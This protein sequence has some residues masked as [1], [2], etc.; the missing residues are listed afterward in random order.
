MNRS[1]LLIELTERAEALRA[2]K[3]ASALSAHH[4]L[5]AIAEKCG[6]PYEG[7]TPL[8][9]KEV[10]PFEEERLRYLFK[11]IFRGSGQLIA[12]FY[13]MDQGFRVADFFECQGPLMAEIAA[14]RGKRS[15]TADLAFLAAL[16]CLGADHRPAVN[17]A[18][19]D[20]LSIPDLLRETDENIY[21]Y[22]IAAIGAIQERLQKKADRAKAL[23]DWRPAAKFMEPEALEKAFYAALQVQKEQHGLRLPHF[24]GEEKPLTLTFGFSEGCWYVHDNGD[25]LSCLKERGNFD[26]V[27]ARI[28]KNLSVEKGR[29]IGSFS[30]PWGFF[31]YLQTLVF[32]AHGDLYW[33]QL[34]EEGLY[35]DSDI[36][37]PRE[38][39]DFDFD[40]LLSSL[41]EKLTFDYD[42]QMG[43]TLGIGMHYSL[44]SG[45][46]RFA[47]RSRE[48]GLLLSDA[49]QGATEGEILENFFWGHEDIGAYRAYLAPYL[50]RFGGEI[51]EN[52]LCLKTAEKN[53][54]PALFRFF[55]LAVL[56]SELG[57][58]I[59]L[60]EVKG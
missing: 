47:I 44:N 43:L 33:Q 41:K 34:D 59:D 37:F 55:N 39:E 42:E 8:D 16:A 14:A 15:L 30:Q 29:I 10:E 57:R 56:C 51:A 3:G 28:R 52:A 38:S 58:L 4:L 53:W 21:D 32:A 20:D 54:L 7:L 26:A 60:S 27:F 35:C 50:A 13:Q 9:D 11:R 36:S 48:E 12:R 24:F 18:F 45:F 22:T 23:R 46:A 17:A 2:K 6:T 40:A 5:A 49:R 19:K 1:L 31:H 25:A